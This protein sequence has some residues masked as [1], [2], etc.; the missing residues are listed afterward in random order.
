M[1]RTRLL[2]LTVVALV[3]GGIMGSGI[4]AVK[5]HGNDYSA[6]LT[7]MRSG[8]W[9]Q[10][11]AAVEQI[12]IMPEA[13]KSDRVKKALIDLLER[14]NQLIEDT[15]RESGE[16]EGV[17]VKYGEEYSEY[18]SNALLDTVVKVADFNDKRTLEALVRSSYNY[19]S[20]FAL[21]LASYGEAVVPAL[22]ERAASDVGLTRA[23]AI[24]LL[25]QIVSRHGDSITEDSRQKIKQALLKNASHPNTIVQLQVVKVLG[26]VGDK[27]AIPALERMIQA[28]SA[29]TPNEEGK[30]PVPEKAIKAIEAIRQRES[31]KKQ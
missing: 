22:L 1:T 14:E 18:Y 27:D 31:G 2:G 17:S 9:Q 21:K 10:R 3:I 11:A 30:S 29:G 19:D 26:E 25:G 13:L 12:I 8:Q 5:Q 20:P 15:L 7:Q 23:D 4:L 16:Q 6:L 28:S 24:G